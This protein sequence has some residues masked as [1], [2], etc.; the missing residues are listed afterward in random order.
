[1]NIDID[2]ECTLF[3]DACLAAGRPRRLE[4][5]KVQSRIYITSISSAYPYQCVTLSAAAA[6]NACF[7]HSTCLIMLCHLHKNIDIFKRIQFKH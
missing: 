7:E 5:I 4:V 1:M 2:H 6:H 3:A